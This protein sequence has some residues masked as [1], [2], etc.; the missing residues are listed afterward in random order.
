[1]SSKAKRKTLYDSYA[2]RKRPSKLR[3]PDKK[4]DITKKESKRGGQL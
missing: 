1:M 3:R 2:R 4:V